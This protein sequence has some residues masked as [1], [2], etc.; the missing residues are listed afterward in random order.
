MKKY[1]ILFFLIAFGFKNAAQ[2]SIKLHLKDYHDTQISDI[3]VTKDEK[4]IITIDNYGKILKYNTEDFSYHSKLKKSDGFFIESPRLIYNERGLFYKSKDSLWIIDSNAKVLGKNPFKGRLF[5]NNKIGPLIFTEEKD[6][7]SSVILIYNDNFQQIKAFKTK[8]KITSANINKDTTHIAYVEEHYTGKQKL[9]YRD[10]K[11]DAVL[12]ESVLED[13]HKIIHSFLNNTDNTVY[14]I[15]ISKEE[16]VVSVYAYKNGVRAKNP[17]V[18]T[19]WKSLPFSTSVSDYFIESNTIIITEKGF[20]PANPIVINFKNNSFKISN[21]NSKKGAYTAAYIKKNNKIITGNT[22]NKNFSDIASFSVFNAK[23]KDEISTHPNFTKEFYK[24]LYLPD[25]SFIIYGSEIKKSNIS[26]NI[27]YYAKGTFYDRFQTLGFE[28]YIEVNHK[29]SFTSNFILDKET[30]LVIFYG[31]DLSNNDRYIFKYSFIE[32]KVIKL[33][34]VKDKYFSIIDYDETSKKLLLSPKKYYNNGYTEP[35]PLAVITNDKITE[36]KGLYKFA[37]FSKKAVHILTI[38]DKNLVQIRDK[39]LNIIFEEQLKDGS[40]LLS[41]ADESFIVSNSFQQI[42]FG[43]CFKESVFFIP[44]KNKTFKSE[45]KDCFY[46]NDL[47]SKNGRIA[48]LIEGLGIIVDEKLISIA[49]SNFPKNISFNKDAS[50]LMVSYANGKTGVIDTETRK[51]IGGMFHPSEKTHI[52]YDTENHYFSNME[53]DDF[54]YATKNKKRVS[55]KSVDPIIF[56]PT[57]VLS[58]FGEPNKEYLTLLNKAVNLRKNKKEYASIKTS[59]NE[60]VNKKIDKKGD[61]YVLSI[62]VSEYKQTAY[63]LTFADKDAFDIANVYGKLDSI[64]IKDFKDEFLGDRFTLQTIQNKQVA[65]LNRYKEYNSIGD[66]YSISSDDKIWLEINYGKALIWNFNTE[67]IKKIKLPNDFEKDIFSKQIYKSQNKNEFYVRSVDSNFYKINYILNTIEKITLPFEF[68]YNDYKNYKPI[69]NNKWLYATQLNNKQEFQILFASENKSKIDT[70]V[71][72]L[73]K[74]LFKKDTIQMESYE[75]LMPNFK[76]ISSSGDYILYTDV[77]DNVYKIKLS[78]EN[79]P[80]KLPFSI[81]YGDEASISEDGTKITVLSSKLNEFRHKII[82]YNLKGEV[83]NSNTFVDED[84]TIKGMS[85]ANLKPKWIQSNAAKVVDFNYSNFSSF[86]LLSNSTPFSF[87]KSYVKKITN[88][89]ATK[90]N[91]EAEITNFLKNTKEEDQVIVFIAGHGVLDKKNNYYYAP[92]NMDFSDVTKNG[93]AF[94]TIIKGL[95]NIKASRKLL[96]MDTCHAGNTLDI[97]SENN[98]TKVLGKEGERGTI[99]KSNKKKPSFKVSEIIGNLFEDF[100]STSGITILSAS[101]GSDVA[102][103]N[104][105]LSNGAFT[106]AYLKVLKNK[107]GFLP[108]LKD[109]EKSV[110]IDADFIQEVLKQVMIL[111]NGKQVPDI[112]EINKNTIIKAW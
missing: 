101:S 1:I 74:H 64:T 85:I 21:L 7:L 62:G 95:S 8:D 90:E 100:M 79:I 71:L 35:Q 19:K 98:G 92:Y 55:L 103:E 112:R 56:K 25:D 107:F 33:H 108:K 86:K 69:K 42:E 17:E 15:T 30:G 44:Q 70:T 47:S 6:I 43:K 109:L 34:K 45:K 58:V 104:K 77:S 75:S 3:L 41:K 40:Y 54:L 99:T 60:R 76:S 29:V 57:K 78:K 67:K 46:I 83:L 38:S 73:K 22:F 82:T 28:N 5:N 80:I 72:N 51:E 84:Y 52:F 23:K 97:E 81:T 59:K 9:I 50:K 31:Y 32:D 105:E 13:S 12:W 102:Y 68:K 89:D 61:L 106:S 18:K 96:L 16:N 37:Q 63:N 65:S 49:S 20:S 110:I 111:T 26:N 10:L 24:S 93:V 88:T 39:N 36:L 94:N 91:I 11:S 53:A 2:D 66:M 87:N 14:A 27:K 48:L 4:R